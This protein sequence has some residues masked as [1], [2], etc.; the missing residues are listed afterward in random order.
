[1]LLF[2]KDGVYD[3]YEEEKYTVELVLEAGPAAGYDA[4]RK[5][6]RIRYMD[7]ESDPP[8]EIKSKGPYED[9]M[10]GWKFDGYQALR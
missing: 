9:S 4:P 7:Y 3:V 5:F 10:W 2:V 6:W 1:M 8:K